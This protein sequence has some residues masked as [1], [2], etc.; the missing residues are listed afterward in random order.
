ME[1]LLP[2]R[3]ETRH[4]DTVHVS[5]ENCPAEHAAGIE[6]VS[7]HCVPNLG[8]TYK[9]GVDGQRQKPLL[10]RRLCF[11]SC[12]LSRDLR[13]GHEQKNAISGVFRADRL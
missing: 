12:R 6:Q 11:K 5:A 10:L 7:R 1:D 13:N 9:Y 8:T 3:V 4:P 2:L